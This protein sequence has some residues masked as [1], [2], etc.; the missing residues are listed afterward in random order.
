[1]RIFVLLVTM[2]QVSSMCQVACGRKSSSEFGGPLCPTGVLSWSADGRV[3]V[4]HS[5]SWC[6]LLKWGRNIDMKIHLLLFSSICEC[7][8]TAIRVGLFHCD[9]SEDVDIAICERIESVRNEGQK[10]D[11][12]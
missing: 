4:H 5:E 1:M 2:L 9:R 10:I 7:E 3:L 6:G 12:E 8:A 11:F